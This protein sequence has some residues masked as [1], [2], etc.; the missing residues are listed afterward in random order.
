MISETA[1]ARTWLETGKAPKDRSQEVAFGL[2]L[3]SGQVEAT[4]GLLRS[5][6]I[7]GD[8]ELALVEIAEQRADWG[9]ITLLCAH[10]GSK[11]CAKAAKKALFR[12]RQRGVALPSI[13]EPRRPVALSVRPDPMPSF[14]TGFDRVGNHVVALGGWS[15]GDAGWSLAGVITAD[16]RLRGVYYSPG[17]SRSRVRSLLERVVPGSSVMVEIPEDC[18]AGLLRHALDR[19]RDDHTTVEGD[20]LRATRLLADVTALGDLEVAFDDH[21]PDQ[22]ARAVA[23]AGVY[24]QTPA[25]LSWGRSLLGVAEGAARGAPGTP[26]D[27]KIVDNF[28]QG[29]NRRRWARRLEIAA[30]L[31]SQ[32][33]AS[34]AALA[35]CATAQSLRSTDQPATDLPLIAAVFAS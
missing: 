28:L 1:S 23:G 26:V 31:L 11:H 15:S 21:D 33:G 20:V 10:A 32:D 24:A 35:A 2:V 27:A 17:T 4:P 5:R 13:G 29:D 14:G 30:L 34:D 8:V 6:P 16:D 7:G 19:A 9:L 22:R 25:L 12:A 18:A 3:L